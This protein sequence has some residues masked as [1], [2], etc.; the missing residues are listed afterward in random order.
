MLS[1]LRL[2]ALQMHSDSALARSIRRLLHE[3]RDRLRVSKEGSSRN[4]T[5]DYKQL[6]LGIRSG[7]STEDSEITS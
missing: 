2:H 1:L 4:R 6:D 5:A 3:E 7:E